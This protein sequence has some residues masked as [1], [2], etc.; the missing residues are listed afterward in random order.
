MLK[1]KLVLRSADFFKMILMVA[2]SI[3]DFIFISSC[4][5]SDI[6][7]SKPLS[8]LTSKP[9]KLVL[10]NGESNSPGVGWVSPEGD[11]MSIAQ[12]DTIFRSSK[13]SVAIHMARHHVFLE[14]GWQWSAWTATVETNIKSY[15]KINLSVKVD[16]PIRPDDMMLSL[17]SPGDHHTTQRVSLKLYDPA[18]MDGNWHDLS[19]PLA[20]LFTSDMKFDPAHAIQIIFAT[21]NESGDFLLYLDDLSVE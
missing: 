16:G 14:A 4:N 6:A 18:L 20:D 21:W 10:W 7:N 5:S 3:L 13:N 2:F 15:I 11:S 1:I 9:T 12:Q 19:I 8:N 17:A